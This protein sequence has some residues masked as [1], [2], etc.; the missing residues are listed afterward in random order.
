MAKD[1]AESD[2]VLGIAMWMPPSPQGHKETWKEW[3]ESWKLWGGQVAMNLWYGRGGLN[4][5]VCFS[6]HCMKRSVKKQASISF[7]PF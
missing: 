7:L 3:S 4:V 6:F 2:K 1:S 5:K